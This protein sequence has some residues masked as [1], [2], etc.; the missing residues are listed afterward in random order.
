MACKH[1]RLP[2]LVALVG[3]LTLPLTA[4]AAD[5]PIVRSATGSGQFR[6]TSDTGVT[7]LHTFSFSTKLSGAL[8]VGEKQGCYASIQEA[9]DAAQDG[10]T[11]KVGAGT[12]AGGITIT[13]S[14]QL[15]GLSAAAT[16]IAGG[17]PVITIGAAGADNGD[18]HVGISRVTVTGGVNDTAG[19]SA[20]GGVAILQGA[21]RTDPGATVTIDSS[22]ISGNRAVPKAAFDPSQP[23]ACSALMPRVVA[24]ELASAQS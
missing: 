1:A 2:L 18:L 5:S 16:T 22:V 10:D 15:V 24:V 23:S 13:K 14:L 12:F 19:N 20:G 4:P 11:I 8:C 7:A 3:A 17:G 21:G 9:V 6:F